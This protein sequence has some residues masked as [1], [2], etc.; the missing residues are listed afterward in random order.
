LN[1]SKE[2]LLKV[3]FKPQPRRL[4]LENSSRSGSGPAGVAATQQQRGTTLPFERDNAIG[5]YAWNPN[6]KLEKE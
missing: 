4:E 1:I 3:G 6:S 2:V 5:D